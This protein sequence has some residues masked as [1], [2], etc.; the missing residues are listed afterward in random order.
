[1]KTVEKDILGKVDE[2][3]DQKLEQFKRRKNL[4][5]YRLTENPEKDTKERQKYDEIL[6]KQIISELELEDL[7]FKTMRIGKLI[8][9]KIRP[10]KIELEEESDK[11]KIL[12]RAKNIRKTQI[13]KFKRIII[14]TDMTFKEREINKILRE[15]LKARRD[16]GEKNLK[17][18]DGKIV[19]SVQGGDGGE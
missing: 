5:I 12:T 10:I 13:A 15:E 7:K 4:V 17:I 9:N 16:A 8:T 1:M 11:F 2:E 3:I 19:P 18:K 6:I 14:T